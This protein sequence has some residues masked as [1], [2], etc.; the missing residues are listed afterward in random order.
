MA[1][2]SQILINN[3]GITITTHGKVVFQAGQHVFQ[4]GEKVV[5]EF[6]FLPALLNPLSDLC[7]IKQVYS[8]PVV[9]APPVTANSQVTENIV[10]TTSS[11]TTSTVKC[12]SHIPKKEDKN[13]KLKFPVVNSYPVDMNGNAI[14]NDMMLW[15]NIA[16]RKFDLLY[17]PILNKITATV[18]LE[19]KFCDA[20]QSIN[21]I[22]TSVPYDLSQMDK[23]LQKSIPKVYDAKKLATFKTKIEDTLNKEIKYLTPTQCNQAGGC[24]CKIPMFLQVEFV[25]KGRSHQKVNLYPKSAR[26]NTDNWAEIRIDSVSKLP[27]DSN[28][29][30]TFAHEVGHYFNFVDEYY[31]FGGM[32]HKMYINPKTKIVDLTIPE[33][34]TDWVKKSPNNLMGSGAYSLNPQIPKYYFNFI[35]DWFEKETRIQ[36]N[37]VT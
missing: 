29:D 12:S 5:G 7:P 15:E 18:I 11:A 20:V 36:W 28:K 3:E 17:D 37:I 4:G 34:T 14:S 31:Y 9:Y 32:V 13:Y 35:K 2:G 24:A 23:K 21:G 10:P 6:P 16:S 27:L 8:E 25:E 1:G 19:V 22:E 26:A 30:H 33:S